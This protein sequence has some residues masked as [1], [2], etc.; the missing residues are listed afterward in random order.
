MVARERR[1]RSP[2]RSPRKVLPQRPW[3]RSPALLLSQHPPPPAEHRR[4]P[5]ARIPAPRLRRCLPQQELH[6]Y[7]I[8]GLRLPLSRFLTSRE[9]RPKVRRYRHLRFWSREGARRW[10]SCAG[11]RGAEAGAGRGTK[12]RRA[13]RSDARA[14]S[15]HCL[16]RGRGGGRKCGLEPG[17]ATREH[18]LAVSRCARVS[19]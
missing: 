3:Q 13:W 4:R 18:G 9:L 8:S 16:V 12:Q 10:S 5:L 6:T 14:A 7:G 1:L 15:R 19:S 11:E 2:S 17:I